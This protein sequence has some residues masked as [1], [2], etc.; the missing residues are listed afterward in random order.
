[1]HCC[2][3]LLA[4]GRSPVVPGVWVRAWGL[5][6]RAMCW[7]TGGEQKVAAFFAMWRYMYKYIIMYA[8]YTCRHGSGVPPPRPRSR[9][10]FFYCFLVSIASRPSFALLIRFL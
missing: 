6:Q 7:P 2:T 5:L 10:C 4:V 3:M 1:M 9:I 8:L